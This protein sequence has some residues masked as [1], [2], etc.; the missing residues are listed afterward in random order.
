MQANLFP[1]FALFPC[2]CTE[3]TSIFFNLVC[4]ILFNF[5]ASIACST[6]PVPF[7]VLIPTFKV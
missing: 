4:Y 6:L 2:R 7:G 3:T 1:I 5:F